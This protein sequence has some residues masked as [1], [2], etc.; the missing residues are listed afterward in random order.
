[1]TQTNL[2]ELVERLKTAFADNL[3]GVA[4]FGSQARGDAAA[5]SDYDL[6]IVLE[7]LPNRPIERQVHIMRRLGRKG[8][9]SI[10]AK[11]R[12]E[13]ESVFPSLYLDLA[14]DGRIL[15][16]RNGYLA[17]R[18]GRVRELIAGAGLVRRKQRR[19]FAWDW[20]RKHGPEWRV[21][22]T[23]VYGIV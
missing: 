11:T 23:G 21:D 19:G 17:A 7:G 8:S 4:L 12:H 9:A 18:L 14:V 3:W 2:T 20:A 10:I 6:F 15:F 5:G 13:F 1:M 16:D 22:W